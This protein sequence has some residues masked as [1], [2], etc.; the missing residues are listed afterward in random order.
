M[1]AREP[2]NT[3]RI[4]LSSIPWLSAIFGQSDPFVHGA[5]RSVCVHSD[6][7]QHTLA[8]PRFCAGQA[9]DTPGE[10]ETVAAALPGGRRAAPSALDATLR[11]RYGRRWHPCGDTARQGGWH[12][13]ARRAPEP[14]LARTETDMSQSGVAN[15]EEYLHGLGS[16]TCDPETF[17][18]GLGR[19]AGVRLG[20]QYG[21]AFEVFH[22]AS[23]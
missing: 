5:Y 6:Q 1:S 21:A 3:P 8:E 13:P 22:C 2:E 7:A 20:T 17:L 11:E 15:P 10:V 19:A 4:L 9:A 16:D 23:R 18:A 12:G 14:W